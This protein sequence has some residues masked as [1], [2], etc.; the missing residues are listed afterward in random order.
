MTAHLT[1]DEAELVARLREACVGHPHAKVAWPHR[2]LHEAADAISR[3]AEERGQRDAADHALVD[4][5]RDP[6]SGVFS[7]PGD[8]AA[9]V[10]RLEAAEARA[11]AAEAALS[12]MKEALKIAEAVLRNAD[13]FSTTDDGRIPDTTPSMAAERARRALAQQ[14]DKEGI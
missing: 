10:L 7:F 14:P 4:R 13:P 8:V 9:I 6:K 2:V 11:T 1:Q 3:I 12:Q 5:Y